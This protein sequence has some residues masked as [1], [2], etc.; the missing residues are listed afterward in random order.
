MPGAF[1]QDSVQ[2]PSGNGT[3]VTSNIA[4]WADVSFAPAPTY[5]RFFPTPFFESHV[6]TQSSTEAYK[7]VLS[8]SGASQP[9]FDD[10][11]KRIV[12]ETMSGTTTYVGSQSGKKGLID[13]PDDAGGLEP[14]P[15]TTRPADWDADNDGI[16]DWWDGSTGGEGYTALEGYL[17]FM[18]EPHAFVAPSA[19]VSVD[20]AALAAGFT[21]PTFQVSGATKGTVAVSGTSANYQAGAV[22]GIDYFDIA[23]RDT[24]GSTWTRRFGVVIAA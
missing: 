10:H 2:Y 15:S 19:A 5:Q 20:L 13:H 21:S 17:N 1:T 16:A 11:D 24:E 7:R 9:V 6:E 18:A 14:F 22:I 23:I 4:C 12:R 3:S 8:D